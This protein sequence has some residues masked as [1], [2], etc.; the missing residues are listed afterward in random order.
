[1]TVTIRL[2]V[3]SDQVH[4]PCTEL[5]DR[6]REAAQVEQTC[7]IRYQIVWWR[8]CR[9]AKG[10]RGYIPDQEMSRTAA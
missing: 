7:R 5:C 2:L 9:K 3:S 1:M 10:V 6:G 8:N 4:R